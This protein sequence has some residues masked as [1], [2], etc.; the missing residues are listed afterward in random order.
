M[1][2]GFPRQESWSG[3]P[4]PSPGDLP[5]PRTEC[6]SLASL[7]L[8]GGFLTLAPPGKPSVT[9]KNPDSTCDQFLLLYFCTLLPVLVMLALPLCINKRKLPTAR[10]THDSPFTR[11]CLPSLT[12]QGIIKKCR[13]ENNNC[14]VGGLQCDQIHLDICKNKGFGHQEIFNE[15]PHSLPF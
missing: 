7:A 12:F 5:D 8:A 13:T 11:L 3:L 9:E 6:T 4:F 1:D 2:R 14:P 10:N 15:Q